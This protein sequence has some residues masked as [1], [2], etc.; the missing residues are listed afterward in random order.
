MN[1]R[2]I[3]VVGGNAA[4]AAA[5]AKAARTDPSATV[6]LIEAG[7]FI[8][9]GTCELP[10]VLSGEISDYK[11]IVFFDEESFRIQKGVKV[12]TNSPVIS[13]N[14][15]KKE[16][17]FVREQKEEILGYDKLILSTGAKSRIPDIPEIIAETGEGRELQNFLPFKTVSNLLRVQEEVYSAKHKRVCIIG[18]GFIGLELCEAFKKLNFE[19]ML[20]EKMDQIFPSGETEAGKIFNE[21]LRE[22]NIRIFTN[23]SKYKFR[24]KDSRI[25]NLI[26]DGYDFEVDFVVNATG[27]IPQNRIALEAGLETGESGALRVNSKLQTS[28]PNIYAAGDN[29]ENIN[30]I[31]R[32]PFYFPLAT[33]AQK[34]GHIAGEN[35]TGGNNFMRPVIPAITLK[36]FDH[37][38]G[39]VG[40][41][42]ETAKKHFRNIKSV[43]TTH[44]NLVPVMPGSRGQWGKIIYAEN[45]N[46]LGASFIGG[47]EV[48]GLADIVSTAIRFSIPVTKLDETDYNYTPALSPFIN[49]LSILG[50]KAKS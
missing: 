3:V 27:F 45:G 19:I 13:L 2:K 26:I 23:A 21:L 36:C 15:R 44:R 16:I 29:T 30:L 33:I 35:A 4:G 48:S 46:I 18:S 22:M 12:L 28:D 10:Y 47:K 43:Q 24:I 34:E 14:R 1:P 31:T 39:T 20:I 17:T 25:T 11:K 41:N 37:Y 8:S 42:T 50:R 38:L 32:R 7:N 40:L 5:A 6:T 9:T 49:I